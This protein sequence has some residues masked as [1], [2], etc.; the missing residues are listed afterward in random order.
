VSTVRTRLLCT[1]GVILFA[2]LWSA[3][4]K[5]KKPHHK[6]KAFIA[7]TSPAPQFA[8]N[9]PTLEVAVSYQTG[10]D[11]DDAE[12]DRV[13]RLHLR[14]DGALVGS[15]EVPP[16]IRQGVYIFSVD[17]SS[18]PDAVVQLEAILLLRR[19]EDGLR[20]SDGGDEGHSRGG[21]RREIHSELVPVI[22]D[23]TPPV[24]TLQSP[25]PDQIFSSPS[26]SV[27]GT[28][29][30]NLSGVGSLVVNGVLTT[31]PGGAFQTTMQLPFGANQLTVTAIDRAGNITT[32]QRIVL[33][34]TSQNMP[35][36]IVSPTP[37]VALV[38]KAFQY[39][40]QAP[41][42]DLVHRV[43]S[44]SAAPAGMVIDPAQG[45][46][47][48]TPT[49]NEAGDQQVT[50]SVTDTNGQSSQSFTI[51]VFAGQPVTSAMISAAQGGAMTVNAPGSPLNGLTI[52][53]PAGALPSD[54]M[55]TISQLSGPSTLAGTSRFMLKGFTIDPDGTPL[56]IPATIT[57]PYSTS[58]FSANE[59]VPLPDFLGVY[60]MDPASGGLSALTDFSVDAVNGV[61]SGSVPHFSAYLATNFF[62]LCPPPTSASDC[63]GT[64]ATPN[65]PSTIIPAI[66]VHGYQSFSS[67]GMA[68][69]TTW[70]QLRYML[71]SLDDNGAGHIDAWRF[72]WDSNLVSFGSSRSWFAETA[73]N[74]RVA[75][76]LIKKFS[77]QAQ[78]NLVA[79]SFGGIVARAY[80]QGVATK[81]GV[82][83]LFQG[84]IE[85]L[86]TLGTPHRGIGG[87]YSTWVADACALQPPL[88][89]PDTCFEA[90]TGDPQ[91][92]AEGG[93]L[94]GLNDLGLPSTFGQF[95][96]MTGQTLDVGGLVVNMDDGL[97]T[98][99]GS[100]F[101][102]ADSAI[103][104]GQGQVTM[105]P[106]IASSASDP[107]GLCHSSA[108]LNI[109]CAA[110]VNVPMAQINDKTHPLWQKICTFLGGDETKCKP[111]LQVSINPTSGGTVTS[112]L[113]GINCGSLC[114][115]AYDP[116]STVTL[117]P[118]PN[119]GFNFTGW[120]GDCV[121]TGPCVLTMN[122]DKSVTATFVAIPLGICSYETTINFIDLQNPTKIDGSELIIVQQGAPGANGDATFSQIS[123]FNNFGVIYDN[124]S[125]IQF[126]PPPTQIPGGCITG[127]TG[128]FCPIAG[129]WANEIW[130]SLTI[131]IGNQSA[132]TVPSCFVQ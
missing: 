19:H 100:N 82:P 18:H 61:I 27:Q 76:S 73:G 118:S 122:N 97:I 91:S 81:A 57:L 24:V 6:D 51:S 22:L 17:V 107:L 30:D 2:T 45:L 31:A 104:C 11:G 38:G 126:S 89:Q 83:E 10:G 114:I 102:A 103:A 8:T 87:P 70:G 127:T 58:D 90:N 35:P 101:C 42:A 5:E 95:A 75:I 36:V 29:T 99:A 15:Y 109:T 64:P 28:V 92:P 106:P 66:V 3:I 49:A 132:A 25:L 80:V 121:G 37:A 112:D 26:T 39:Q 40:V 131:T 115:G 7:I 117:T 130:P 32:I 16:G 67:T 85:N 21:D 47:S 13:A 98:D 94:R 41:S 55:L 71:N 33:H 60:Y 108:L 54:T 124:A 9:A 68:N 12:K 69:E 59:G 4:A 77:N 105:P 86:M 74:L 129:Y 23:K 46:V 52:T 79:H 116:N 113:P 48:W 50:V 123:V 110:G 65:Q 88:I 120:A 43:F 63:P 72:D 14:L 119:P 96:V 62:R 34:A 1:I 93:F 20:N 78:V 56:A 125:D 53:I 128:T 111:Q 44:L 84:D